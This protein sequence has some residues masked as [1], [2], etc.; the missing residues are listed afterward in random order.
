[1]ANAAIPTFSSKGWIQGD[2]EIID[3]I[4]SCFFTTRQS[5]SYTSNNVSSVQY[6]LHRYRNIGDFCSQVEE[7]LT[8][9][10]NPYF[11]TV[12]VE[13]TSN[14][15]EIQDSSVTVSIRISVSS[16]EKSTIANRLIQQSDSRMSWI[17][18]ANDNGE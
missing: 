1:M 5:Q 9:L 4:L 18:S 7:H 10:Y 6:L 13:V 12:Q 3:Y 14:T 2:A 8:S 17:I 16:G 11:D 15:R